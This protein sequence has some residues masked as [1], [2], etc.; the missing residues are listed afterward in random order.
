MSNSYL[1]LKLSIVTIT[2]LL[3]I[4]NMKRAHEYLRIFKAPNHHR[5]KAQA[6]VSDAPRYKTTSMALNLRIDFYNEDIAEIQTD[7]DF[8]DDWR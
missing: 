6:T 7:N 4:I 3:D 1:H 5:R 8:G 2:K